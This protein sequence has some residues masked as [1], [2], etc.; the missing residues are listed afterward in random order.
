MLL[1][2]GQDEM[3]FNMPCARMSN[4]THLLLVTGQDV[5]QFTYCGLSLTC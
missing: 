5:S 3:K 2:I 1:V 4:V